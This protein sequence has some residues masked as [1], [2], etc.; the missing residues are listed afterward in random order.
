MM[1]A[2]STYLLKPK[3]QARLRPLLGIVA[4][5]GVTANQVTLAT[6]ALS[7]G[8]GLLLISRPQDQALL[9]LLPVLL[10]FRMALNAMDGMLAR[11]FCQQS[12]L[13]ACLNEL[14]DVVS[15]AFLYLP[16]VYLQGFDSVWMIAVVLLAVVSEMAGTVTVMIGGSRRYDGPMGKSDRA[17][18]FGALALWCGLRWS[19]APW[20]SY[21]FPRLMTLL[22]VTTVINRIKKGLEETNAPIATGGING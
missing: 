1:S 15:D 12:K 19:V 14:G 11:E 22:L 16:F 2:P 20:A 21:V 17:L 6:C 7:V 4:D 18:V 13:G 9:L 3:F 10:F 5:S 8:F